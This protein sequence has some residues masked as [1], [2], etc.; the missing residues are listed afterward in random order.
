MC[1]ETQSC[2]RA[3]FLFPYCPLQALL[4]RKYLIPYRLNGAYSCHKFRA[5]N[6]HCTVHRCPVAN[7]CVSASLTVVVQGQINCDFVIPLLQQPY[8]SPSLV[9]KAGLVINKDPQ[10][11]CIIQTLSAHLTRCKLTGRTSVNKVQSPFWKNDLNHRQC[12]PDFEWLHNCVMGQVWL[13]LL[14][15]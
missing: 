15:Q 7:E 8:H 9:L 14:V 2:I 3:S 13:F 6:S 5:Y 11:D 1:N 4:Y 10:A 12:K